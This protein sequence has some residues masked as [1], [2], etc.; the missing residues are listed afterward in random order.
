[1]GYLHPIN[2]QQ[3]QWDGW[4][5]EQHPQ[6]TLTTPQE[7]WL[8]WLLRS[9][10]ATIMTKTP[11]PWTLATTSASMVT[12]RERS[13]GVCNIELSDNKSWTNFLFENVRECESQKWQMIDRCQKFDVWKIRH[14]T[15]CWLVND[16]YV[17][18]F[19][20]SGMGDKMRLA[21]SLRLKSSWFWLGTEKVS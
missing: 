1:M 16:W 13:R 8:L 14:T 10:S 5:T 12:S 11:E 21:N 7:S 4:Q 9:A 6:V 3:L 2:D 19:N 20:K 15:S 18:W 17:N